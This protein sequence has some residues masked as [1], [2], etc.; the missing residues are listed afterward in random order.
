MDFLQSDRLTHDLGMVLFFRPEFLFF[1][2]WVYGSLPHLT[3]A[4][5]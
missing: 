3:D 2:M 5:D 1:Q 4:L